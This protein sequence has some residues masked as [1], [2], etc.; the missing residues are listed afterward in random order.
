MSRKVSVTLTDRQADVLGA[1]AFVWRLTGQSREAAALREV[2]AWFCAEQMEN[3][4]IKE[5]VA[6]REYRRERTET[7]PAARRRGLRVVDGGVS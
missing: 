2:V 3:V 4:Q 7:A 6:A 1:S 5:L